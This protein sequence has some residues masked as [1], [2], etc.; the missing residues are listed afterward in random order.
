LCENLYY[1]RSGER[2]NIVTQCG[3]QAVFLTTFLL[4]HEFFFQSIRKFNF[5]TIFQEK[6][7]SLNEFQKKHSFL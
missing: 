4:S 3:R 1:D 7:E 5:L 6:S 2:D